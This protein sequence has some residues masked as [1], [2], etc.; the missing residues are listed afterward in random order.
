MTIIIADLLF[1]R[2]SMYYLIITGTG[3]FLIISA[4]SRGPLIC[5]SLY[6]VIKMIYIF[7][8]GQRKKVILSSIILILLIIGLGEEKSV[9]VLQKMISSQRLSNRVVQQISDKT[10]F[11]DSAR[12]Q[13]RAYSFDIISAHPIIGVG[14]INDR[15]MLAEKMGTSPEEARGWYPHNIAIEFLVQY[16]TILAV[17]LLSGIGILFIRAVK[18]ST[19][20]DFKNTI[21]IFFSVGVLPLLFSGSYLE[22]PLFFAFLGFCMNSISISKNMNYSH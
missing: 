16:G 18:V 22:S 2:F 20:N 5:F 6:L 3:L 8:S 21:L 9:V 19:D 11:E 17:F 12:V 7:A 10:I 1:S 14:I 4:G 15:V 13:L